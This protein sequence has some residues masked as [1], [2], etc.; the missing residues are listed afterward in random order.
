MSKP[1]LDECQFQKDGEPCWGEV[2]AIDW[3][4]GSDGDEVPI[5]ACEGHEDMENDFS[6][7]SDPRKGKYKPQGIQNDENKTVEPE[8]RS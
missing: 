5:Y 3:H 1:E 2:T 8:N 4:W 6:D 7:H